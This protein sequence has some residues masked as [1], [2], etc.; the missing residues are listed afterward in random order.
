M[1]T[2][3]SELRLGGTSRTAG[4]YP[5]AAEASP[6][7]FMGAFQLV[8][9]DHRERGKCGDSVD[10]YVAGNDV[11]D[12]AVNHHR[13]PRTQFFWHGHI[14]VSLQ[15]GYAFN[16]SLPRATFQSL[17]RIWLNVFSSMANQLFQ[18]YDNLTQTK[19][20]LILMAYV[21]RYDS[22]VLTPLLLSHISLPRL[23]IFCS[24]LP[25]I[26]TTC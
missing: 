14:S 26:K 10:L 3:L 20:M 8:P 12:E 21:D 1:Q 13:W 17:D 22:F 18:D 19:L 2:D 5:R 16:E 4:P 11:I 24:S 7:G 25:P 6:S 9:E 23:L 15:K